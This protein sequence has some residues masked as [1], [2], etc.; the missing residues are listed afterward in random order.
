[1]IIAFLSKKIEI[2]NFLPSSDGRERA[3]CNDPRIGP[4]YGGLGLWTDMGQGVPP[5]C[6]GRGRVSLLPS[7]LCVLLPLLLCL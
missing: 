7:N 6:T 3:I 1:M 4:G 2:N 5:P